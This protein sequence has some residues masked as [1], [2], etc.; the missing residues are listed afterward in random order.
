MQFADDLVAE[1]EKTL[2]TAE[3]SWAH[4]NETAQLLP[5]QQRLQVI[6]KWLL[7]FDPSFSEVLSGLSNVQQERARHAH[8]LKF[9][10]HTYHYLFLDAN[11]AY[12][13]ALVSTGHDSLRSLN[14]LT[15]GLDIMK[16]TVPRYLPEKVI[17]QNR[18]AAA[19]ESLLKKNLPRKTSQSVRKDIQALTADV[20]QARCVLNLM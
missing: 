15:K 1:G 6:E 9:Q 16:R 17:Y 13:N 20:E 7:E 11:V 5:P 19:M 8:K 2:E 4:I 18:C 14:G 10:L 3:R 12:F